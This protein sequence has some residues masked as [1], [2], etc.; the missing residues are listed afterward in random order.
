[1]ST[2]S[3][4]L[5]NLCFRL[6]TQGMTL[7]E[8][9]KEVGLPENKVEDYILVHENR[10]FGGGLLKSGQ[11]MATKI[12][13]IE[14]IDTSHIKAN[15][16]GASK[17]ETYAITRDVLGDNMTITS[18]TIKMSDIE[19]DDTLQEEDDFFK[20]PDGRDGDLYLYKNADKQRDRIQEYIE[21]KYK[22][23]KLKVLYMA[24]LHIPFTV[25]DL[26][27][28]ILR[29]HS[30]SDILVLNGDILDLFNVSTFAK[31]K[32]IAL[33]RELQEGREF[34]E[35]VSRLFEDVIVVEGNHE[36]RLRNYIKNVIPVDLHFLFPQDVLEVIQSG[37]VFKKEPLGNVHVVG[38]WW[39]QLFDTIFGHPDN[40]SSVPLRTV[41][42]TS[43]HFKMV[44]NRPHKAC[45]IG[46]THQAGKLIDRGTM[47]METGCL[48]HDVDYKHGS[49]FIKTTWT[50]AHAV[51]Y[52]DEGGN[53]QFNESNVIV[54]PI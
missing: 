47:V 49:K 40:Y 41:I 31:D 52:F 29:E 17:A 14:S 51:L 5:E 50:R 25:Y 2:E 35:I 4:Y 48:Q 30:D 15:P 46:H 1:M 38:S 7:K 23:R 24:D 26:V 37:T 13:P 45:I 36:R 43:E 3:R 33:K 44:K 32:T 8:I 9:A 18:S 12:N 20:L 28:H 11:I 6:K 53:I 54:Y 21:N 16:V 39:I 34:L 42:Q 10:I 19:L 27:N 22:G